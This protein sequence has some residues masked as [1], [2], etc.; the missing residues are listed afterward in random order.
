MNSEDIEAL[1]LTA[2]TNVNLGRHPG[3][4]LDVS[5]TAPIFGA[6]SPLDSLGLVTLL[7]DIEESLADQGIDITL[8]DAQ[9]MSASRSPFRDVPS[10]VGYIAQRVAQV[11]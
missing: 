5:S 2:L 1:V 9:A 10:L 6:K 3:E 7:I 11:S 8:S 4:Q